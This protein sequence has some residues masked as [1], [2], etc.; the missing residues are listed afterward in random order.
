[1]NGFQLIDA[2]VA[3][4]TK[5]K[6]CQILKLIEELSQQIAFETGFQLSQENIKK[7][8]GL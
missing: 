4:N 6:S 1:M 8:L 5:S 2:D 3:Y 7:A